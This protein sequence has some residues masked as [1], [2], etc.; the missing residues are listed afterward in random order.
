M[1][2]FSTSVL[3]YMP[4]SLQSGQVSIIS[5]NTNVQLKLF[6]RPLN[7]YGSVLKCNN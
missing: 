4:I 1:R 7:G 3:G 6:G 5:T 2:L